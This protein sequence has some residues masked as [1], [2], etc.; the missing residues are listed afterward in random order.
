MTLS[1]QASQ[2]YTASYIME[3]GDK[4]TIAIETFT[5]YKNQ[6]YG[7]TVHGFPENYVRHFD[8]EYGEN[9]SINNLNYLYNDIENTSLPIN[10]KTGLL[11][12][13]FSANV[14]HGLLDF[15][16]W[17][18][19]KTDE[20]PK[21]KN[22]RK[23]FTRIIQESDS[24]HFN[25]DWIPI[26]SQFEWL[27]NWFLKQGKE[28]IEGLKFVNA[29][30]GVH[31]LQLER[32]D[33]NHIRFWSNISEEIEIYIDDNGR[34]KTI[35]AIGSVWNL[36]IH[37]TKPVDIEQ[38]T[39]RYKNRPIMGNP[40]PRDVISKKIGETNITVDYGRP[41]KRGRQIFGNVVPYNKIWRTGA[42]AATTISFDKD[43][44]FGDKRVL[45][46]K[47]NVYSLPT[48]NAF[49]LIL[50]SNL[51]AWGSVYLPEY[52]VAQLAMKKSKSSELVDK[53]M[54]EIIDKGRKGVL[55]LSWEATVAELG[56]DLH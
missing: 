55:K 27:V 54:F 12:F 17:K 31:E 32:I 13:R 10:T 20:D 15:K 25:G 42:G 16:I 40:S 35:D 36:K 30:I 41:S 34:I 14:H 22:E 47:Y 53:F 49:T 23:S 51:D 21:N 56:F 26:V 24:F 7:K 50:N 43:I 29:Y 28:K 37:R 4:D 2:P 45:A 38:Y 8:I 46:G 5:L 44:S 39:E 3:W 18:K 33:K 48:E 19:P 11:P 9:G 52:D 1:S 6:L